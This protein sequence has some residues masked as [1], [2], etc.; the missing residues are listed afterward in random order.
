[1]SRAKQYKPTKLVLYGVVPALIKSYRIPDMSDGGPGR[2]QGDANADETAGAKDVLYHLMCTDSIAFM[3]KRLGV[4][5]QRMYDTLDLC[6][7]LAAPKVLEEYNKPQH[8]P[9]P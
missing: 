2:R 3:A 9:N 6:M 7:H 1:M 4:S 5:R 8:G